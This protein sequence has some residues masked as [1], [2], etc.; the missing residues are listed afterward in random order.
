[1]SNT[2]TVIPE[3]FINDNTVSL[4]AKGLLFYLLSF[5][6]DYKIVKKN[7]YLELPDRRGTIDRVFKE[8]QNKG[9]ITSTLTSNGNRLEWNHS[10][11]F[12]KIY[13]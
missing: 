4:P 7:L 6:R 11:C 1:M 9:Y 10:I 12:E 3:S 2:H 13:N 8:L 5:G